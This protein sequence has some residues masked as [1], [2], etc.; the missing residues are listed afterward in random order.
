MKLVE[1]MAILSA[2]EANASNGFDLD[3]L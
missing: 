2:S 3:D 1:S